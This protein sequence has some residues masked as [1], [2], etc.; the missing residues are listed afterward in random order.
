LFWADEI[1]ASVT[2]PQVVNDSKTPSGTVHVG[3][4]RGVLIHDA[5]VRAL[6]D[7]GRPVRFLYGID[8]DDP[9]DAQTLASREGLPG[10]MGRPLARVPAPAGSP[11]P[12]WARH[13]AQPYLDTFE[14]LGV[15]HELYW[16]SELYAAGAFD[17]FIAEALDKRAHVLAVYREVSNVRHPDDWH[18]LQVI[19]ERC[20][21]VGTTFVGGWDGREVTYRCLPELVRWA[22]GCGNRGRVS[23]FSGAAKLPWNLE[24]VAKWRHFGVTIEGAGKDLSTKGGSRDRSEALA[25]R[26]FDVTPPRNIAYEFVLVAG[27]R[28][29]TSGGTG[30]AAHV[31]AEVLPPELV[32]FLML[33][34]RP[35]QAIEFD[36]AGE[37]IP[38]LFDE[39]DAYVGSAF[40]EADDGIPPAERAQRRRIVEISQLPGRPVPRYFLAPFVQVATY[41]Q[42]PGERSVADQIARHRGAP[43]SAEERAEVERRLPIAERW[44]EAWAPDRHRFQV[45]LDEVPP[46]VTAMA[47]DERRYLAALADRLAAQDT[48][49]WQPASVQADVHELAKERALAPG[50]AFG[51]IYTAFL[52]KRNGPRAGALLA[53]LPRDKVLERLRDA[54][55]DAVPTVGAG[56]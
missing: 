54:A 28:M 4:L 3:S 39:Y 1:A 44:L 5:I 49:A 40:T 32:R 19:C 16:V 46:A 14:R 52:G 17:A 25:R 23:P 7:A 41:A 36:P 45:V 42:M 56:P 22:T 2:G 20:G 53:S 30:P 27:R 6:G 18:P 11:H 31:I 34:Y 48:A 37:T 15:R 43:L 55:A 51:A 29:R 12:S 8:D 47:D 33:R 26:V 24:W 38:R 21:R 35:Q 10:E 13:Y 9:M 50:R